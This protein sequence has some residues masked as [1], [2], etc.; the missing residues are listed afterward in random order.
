MDVHQISAE[1]IAG[2][3]ASSFTPK[4]TPALRGE[5]KTVLTSA[6]PRSLRN[7]RLI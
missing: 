1:Y 2:E 6:N 4:L 3:Q 7:L 5:S